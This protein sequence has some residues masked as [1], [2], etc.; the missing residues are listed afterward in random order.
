MA[1]LVVAPFLEPFEDRMEPQ[2]RMLLQLPV[3]R[4]VARIADL[5]RQ[6]GRVEDELRPEKRVFLDF[7]EKTEID[8]DAESFNT[9]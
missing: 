8:A 4:D 7:R 3:D 5:L 2:L 9:R 6:I 1:K